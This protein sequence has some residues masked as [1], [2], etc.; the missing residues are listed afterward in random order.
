MGASVSRTDFE[1]VGSDEPHATRRKV[2]L[3]KHP[4]IKQLMGVDPNFKW[5]VTGIVCIQFI[6]FAILSQV[7][8]LFL[9]FLAS[10]CFVGVLNHTLMLAVHEIA[11]GQAFGPNHVTRNKLF[12]MFANL[13]IG[14]PMSVSFKKYHLPHHRYQ[15]DEVIDTDI[16]CEWEA[17]LFTNTFL[18]FLWV[19]LQPFFYTI[20]P[21]FMYPLPPDKLEA[22]NLFVQLAFNSLVGRLFGW[23]VVG[24]MIFGSIICMGLHPVAGHFISEHY[25]M[26]DRKEEE[27]KESLNEAMALE[28]MPE[29][30]SYYGPLNWITFNVGY[31]VEHHDFPSI[32]GSRLPR[33]KEIAPE[34]YDNLHHH[35]SWTYV[36]YK[37]IMDPDV[38]PFSRVKRRHREEK[39]HSIEN[40][41]KKEE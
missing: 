1:W 5:Q 11:H 32:P 35:T 28:L 23:H 41:A 37:Y 12:G 38:G 7:N 6:A 21:F 13:T 27:K 8:N 36:L 22:V 14:I 30:C 2:I 9:L 10:Y 39:D 15:G 17:K 40:N 20:R 19:I 4:E 29:T 18:K 25:I 24:V 16:P 26:F 34:F 33:V 31:H 3:A